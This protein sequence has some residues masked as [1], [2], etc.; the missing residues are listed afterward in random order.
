ME[1]LISQEERIRRAEEIYQRRK[2]INGSD[3]RVSS[4]SVNSNKTKISLFKKMVLQLAICS[5]IYIIFYFIKNSNYIFSKDVITKTKE[6][7][8]HDINFENAY[9]KVVV[10]WEENKDKFKLP[11]IVENE[12][13]NEIEQD[14]INNSEESNIIENINE[15]ENTNEILEN[16]NQDH[17]TTASNEITENITDKEIT[18]TEKGGIGG[19]DT[20]EIEGKTNAETKKTQMEID[21]EYVKEKC[22]FIIPSKGTVTSRYGPRE[23]TEIVSAYHYG[24]DIGNNIGTAIYASMEGTVTVVSSEGDYR[25]TYRNYK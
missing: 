18:N 22:S 2:M 14:D 5:I 21:A 25:K 8:S 13:I 12:H 6:L 20:K 17:F 7:L 9:S 15:E 23:A 11:S 16:N 24:I 19:A 10:F 3:V 1:R 4:N